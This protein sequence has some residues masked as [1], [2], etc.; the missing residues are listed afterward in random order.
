MSIQK[1]NRK[2]KSKSNRN[3]SRKVASTPKVVTPSATSPKNTTV[4]LQQQVSYSGPLPPPHVLAE[5]DAVFS[6]L[7]ETIINTMQAEGNH[8]REIESR[9]LEA[10][11]SMGNRQFDEARLGQIFGFLI[12]VVSIISGS[13]IAVMGAKWAGG[14][15]GGSGVVGLVS[16]FIYGRK[17]PQETDEPKDTEKVE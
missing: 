16:V 11:I 14:F 3:K 4:A 2:S 12:G 8:R 17:K 15:I 13:V 5:Y 6:G 10:D 7:A 9:A 1:D